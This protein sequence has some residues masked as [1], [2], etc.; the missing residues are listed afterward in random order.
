MNAV[1]FGVNSPV[2]FS[3]QGTIPLRLVVSI[4]EPCFSLL[5][6]S[7][8]I[9]W[10]WILI[11]ALFATGLSLIYNFFPRFASA[12]AFVLVL[13]FHNRNP[14]I[15]YG[16]DNLVRILLFWISFLPAGPPSP[17]EKKFTNLSSVIILLQLGV[18]YVSTGFL[19]A[20]QSW[21]WDGFA[22]YT[23]LR[24]DLFTR[25]SADWLSQLPLWILKLVSRT[26]LLLERFGPIL[27]FSPY[28][29]A[30]ARLLAF[31][32]FLSMHVSFAVIMNVGLFPFVDIVFLTLLLPSEFWDHFSRYKFFHHLPSLPLMVEYRWWPLV[33]APWL[34]VF[35]LAT[36]W[37]NYQKVDNRV[38]MPYQL[39]IFVRA[40]DFNQFW[41]MFAPDPF[42][43]DGW[44]VVQG[45]VRENEFLS[46]IDLLKNKNGPADFSKPDI[47]TASLPTE[48][49]ITYLL[50]IK[51][52]REREKFRLQ[53]AEHFCR[54]WP[55][56]HAQS[57]ERVEV[58][59]MSEF[60]QP[61]PIPSQVKPELVIAKKCSERI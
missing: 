61:Y 36:S 54:K 49:W 10:V 21:L 22:V 46:P 18:L 20:S 7:T 31:F 8:H 34:I 53:L 6:L 35:L 26:V 17:D 5:C 47:V 57:L 33:T 29:F 24:A 37:W 19:K 41:T 9:V 48:R 45:W 3:E 28:R 14:M 23:A 38:R 40:V 4:S 13:S 32:L 16:A 2:F 43:R 30:S 11:A 60:T 55:T 59:F 27:F 1:H 50:S 42:V 25:P 15:I 56:Q 58:W 44:F 12:L 39:R 51:W 52:R